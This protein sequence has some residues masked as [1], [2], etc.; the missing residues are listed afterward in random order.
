MSQWR[1]LV[2]ADPVHGMLQFDRHDPVQRLVLAV[3]NSRAFQRLR[4]IKQ[5]GLAEFVFPGAVHTRFN[6]CLGATHIMG[7]ALGVLRRDR[8]NR[9]LLDS[10]FADTG[11]SLETLL[12][13]GILVHDIGHPPLS[14]TLEDV[15]GLSAKGLNHDYYWLPRILAEDEELL[16]IWER[17]GVPRL[18][19]ALQRFMGQDPDTGEEKHFLAA[20]ISSQLDMDRLDYLLRDSHFL[21]TQYG[22]IELERLVS[23]LEIVP[24]KAGPGGQ[25]VV[26]VLLDALPAL[27][28]YLFGRHQAY[29]MA[30]HP[31][32][33][34]SEALLTMV[35]KRYGWLVEQGI[36]PGGYPTPELAQLM[37]QGHTLTVPQYL[38]LDDYYLWNAIHTWSLESTDP[39]LHSLAGRMMAH[40]LPK[41]VA[42]SHL[43]LSPER[44]AE[45]QATLR[46]HYEAHGL[47]F[48]FGFEETFVPA[49]P[50]YATTTGRQPI[51]MTTPDRG[52]MELSQVSSLLADTGLSVKDGQHLWF[53]WDRSAKQVL[54]GLVKGQDDRA[55]SVV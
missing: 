26:A 3:V 17:F 32:D 15:L 31:L 24:A 22:N 51:W 55:G 7:K 36:E 12:M 41:F 11:V 53:V 34:A 37:T 43:T 52:V 27:E 39:L 20:L 42:L 19:E 10:T 1:W 23:S 44:Q 49:K 9:T 21:G 8:A 28:H 40:D 50:L 4:R 38:R 2:M 14:H 18:P 46:A 54:E 13:V 29:K 6:H 5:M 33:K 47:S 30:L 16:G 25:P 45:M 35:L 48:D